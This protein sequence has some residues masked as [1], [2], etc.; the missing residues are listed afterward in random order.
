MYRRHWC[1]FY[2]AAV[3][4]IASSMKMYIRNM[5]CLSFIVSAIT[6]TR[7]NRRYTRHRWSNNI[8]HSLIIFNK[9]PLLFVTIKYIKILIKLSIKGISEK[10]MNNKQS[11]FVLYVKIYFLNLKELRENDELTQINGFIV[12][13]SIVLEFSNIIIF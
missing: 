3:V 9:V 4:F 11:K 12:I 13:W 1:S 8:I 6:Y 10:N 2:I 7:H 5:N